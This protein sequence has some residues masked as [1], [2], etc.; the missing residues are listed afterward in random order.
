M[1]DWN[2]LHGDCLEL[3]LEMNEDKWPPPSKVLSNTQLT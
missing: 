1:Q 2:Y 3:T